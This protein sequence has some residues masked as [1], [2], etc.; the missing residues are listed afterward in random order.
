MKINRDEAKIA[1]FSMEIALDNKIKSYAGGLGVLAGDTLKSAA[2]LNVSMVGLTI[3]NRQGYFKQIITKQGEQKEIADQYDFRHLKKLNIQTS[4][5]IGTDEVKIR[6]WEYIIV[7]PKGH[8]VPVYF[9]DTDLAGN[10]PKYRELSGH[11]YR[12]DPEYRLMQEIILGRGGVKMLTALGYGQ[13]KKYHLNEGHA[14]LAT[15]ELFN[16]ALAKTNTAKIKEIKN[17]CVFTT[18]TPIKA[19]H[20][21]F[22]L[23]LAK[24]LQPDLPDKLLGLNKK[25]ELNMTELALFFSGYVNGV[26]QSHQE[27]S[28]KM[29]P[30]HCIYSITN[31]VHSPTWTSPEFQ[32]LFDKHIPSWRQSSL[33]LRNAFSI[34]TTEIWQAHQKTKQHL[35]NYIYKKQGIKLDPAIFTLGF[36]RRFTGYKRSTLLFQD[37]DKLIHIN[38]TVGPMQ[39]IYAGKA[40]PS[41]NDGKAM[42]KEINDIKKQYRKDIKIVFLENYD[43]DLA[44]LMVA[45]VDVWLN[46]PLPPNE[47]SGTSGM[48]A[49]HNGVPH[50]STLD[51]WWIEGFVNR[52][53]GWAI[54]ERRSTLEPKELDKQDADNLYE[55]LATR[56][57]PRY[58]E[59]PTNWRE[60]MRYT[61]AINASFFN[62]ERMLQQYIQSA[63]L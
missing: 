9:L 58:Y 59:M 1:Y 50:F 55:K 26:A 56:I 48:K 40:H 5:K 49:A 35:F 18:H 54:G 33:A 24:E 14:A 36:A 30:G 27:V 21:V 19:G 22:S 34:S 31:G 2:D 17:K 12:V 7:S 46:T 4:I 20:D 39:I 52:K 60:T 3:L 53:T 43:L 13:I 38:K 63:Y 16:N 8:S 61:I 37:M 11:L 32:K 6:A 29:F 10:Q 45:G 51:G 25:K 23:S 15:V 28:A 41:D 44:K 62:S 47:A 57:L 42:I